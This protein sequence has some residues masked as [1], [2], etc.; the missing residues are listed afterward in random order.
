MYRLAAE[1]EL[2]DEKLGQFLQQH[3]E[4]SSSS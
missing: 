2:T 3:T 4:E 1:K